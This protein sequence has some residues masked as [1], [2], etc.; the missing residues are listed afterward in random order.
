MALNV[1]EIDLAALCAALRR[2]FDVPPSGYL[3]GRTAVRD[4]V[5]EHL[6]CSELEAEQLVETMIGL[7]F[8]RFQGDPTSAPESDEIWKIGGSL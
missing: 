3:R 4:A 7:G 2:V 5:V 8:L 6:G 1:E